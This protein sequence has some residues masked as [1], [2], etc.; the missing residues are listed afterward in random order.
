MSV[1]NLSSLNRRSFLRV[2]AATA[3]AASLPLSA[4]Q[5]APKRGG[6]LR[7]GLAHGQTT[8][9][10]NPGTW[11][12]SFTVSMAFAVHGYLTEITAD[13]T[14]VPALAESWEASGDASVWRV[15]L[16]SGVA[17]HSGKTVE[18]ADVVNSINFHRGATSTSAA[19]PLVAS[20]T[21]IATEGDDTVIFTLDSGNADFPFTLS[22]YHLAIA[23]ADGEGIDWQSG[24]G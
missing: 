17:F 5:A 2:S 4:A 24:D 11:D 9:T 16:R 21:D 14:V 23:K 10:L 12:N 20:I 1:S 22:D 13:G 6:H 18:V 3:L 19:G 7:A 15:K 8:D